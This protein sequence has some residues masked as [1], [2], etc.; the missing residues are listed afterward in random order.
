MPETTYDRLIRPM[1]SVMTRSIWRILRDQDDVDAVLQE[2][3]AKIW[4][5]AFR[6]LCYVRVQPSACN[7]MLESS[8]QAALFRAAIGA[9]PR[10]LATK[11]TPPIWS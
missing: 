3:L 5:P 1:E 4:G 9:S 6:L 7:V 2:V 11:I 10:S 8:L